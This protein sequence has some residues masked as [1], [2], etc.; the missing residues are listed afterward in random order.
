M[1]RRDLSASETV[2]LLLVLFK[3]LRELGADERPEVRNSGAV[4]VL[5]VHLQHHVACFYGR[6]CQQC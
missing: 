1:R 3:A 2:D 5:I 6:H 4:P